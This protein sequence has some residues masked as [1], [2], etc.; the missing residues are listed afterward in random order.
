M[1]IV[2]TG[3]AGFIGCNYADRRLSQGDDVVVLDNLSRPRTD[4]NLR[5]LRDRHHSGLTFIEADIRDAAAVAAAVKGA[6]AVF[7]LAGQVAV[8]TS[9]SNPR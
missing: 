1:R 5:W 2:I 9:I 8:T 7:H 3:G 6:D 4:L